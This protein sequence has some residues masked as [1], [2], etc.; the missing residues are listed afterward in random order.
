MFFNALITYQEALEYLENNPSVI[1]VDKYVS[2]YKHPRIRDL[3]TDTRIEIS[4]PIFHALKGKKSI[5]LEHKTIMP[6]QSRVVETY[7]FNRNY[8]KY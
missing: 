4:L 3:H 6:D 7:H 5:Y 8:L 1:K 2:C